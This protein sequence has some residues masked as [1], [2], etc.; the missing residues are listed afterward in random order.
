MLGVDISTYPSG[1]ISDQA[2]AAR[3]AA[4]EKYLACIFISGAC[5][6]RYGYTKRYL[7]NEYL[8][9]KDAYPK[10]FEAYLKYMNDYQ[11]LNKSVG[12]KELH[13]KKKS[14]LTLAQNGGGNTTG[15]KQKYNK[16]DPYSR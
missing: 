14:G 11:K 15:K 1:F 2:K 10:K 4:R 8:K 3:K 7:H 9:D 16:R 12:Y 13:R 6:V 5:N